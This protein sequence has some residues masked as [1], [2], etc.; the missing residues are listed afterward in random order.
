VPGSEEQPAPGLQEGSGGR[1]GMLLRALAAAPRDA[2][3]PQLLISQAVAATGSSGGVVGQTRGGDVV[4]LASHGYTTRQRSAC[5]PLR[6]GD[7]SLPLTYAATTGEPVW[8]ASQ[9]DTAARFPR[10]VELV[11]RDE[12]AYAA[13]PLRANGVSL[14]VLGISFAEQHDFTGADQDFLLALSD[15]C[16]IY[17]HQ[18][19][20]SAATGRAAASAAKLGHLVQTMSRAETADEVARL[21]AEEGS[22]AAGAEFANIAVLDP[23]AAPPTAHLYHAASLTEDVARRYAVIPVDASTPLGAVLQSGGEVWLPSLSDTATRYPALLRDTVA[24]GLSATASLALRGR[25]QQVIGA[26]G[27][28]WAQDQDFTSAQQEEVRVVARLAADALGRSQLL[29][30]ERAA[31][32]RTEGVQRAMTALVASASLAEV[33][34]AVFEHGLPPFGATAARLSLLSPRQP[35]Q[36]VT[37][38]AVGLPEAVLAS[39][40]ALPASVRSPEREVL[41]TSGT[42]YLPAPEDLAARFPTAHPVLVAAGHQAWAALPLHSGGR[43]L[44]VLTLAFPRRRPFDDGPGQL[45]LTALGSAIAD[46]LSRAIRHDSDHELVELVQGSLLAGSLPECPGVRLGARYMPAETQYGIGGDWYDA[47]PLPG[48]RILVVVGDVAGRGLTAAITMGQMRS[49][50]RALAPTHGPAALLEALDR[51]AGRTL[52]GSL[53]TAAAAIID[54]ADRTIRYCLAG[55]PPLLLRGPDGTVVTLA[56]ARRPLLG[57]DTGA[58][59]EQVI[60]FASGS[61]LVLFTDG[62]VER[63]GEIFDAGLSRLATALR[64]AAETDPASLCE[65]LVEQSLP[66][67]GRSD[68]TAILCA[69]LG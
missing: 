45:A 41:E 8:L 18:W 51:F 27:V 13:L 24:A 28:A 46:A 65:T 53:A 63:R 30:A 20:E 54:P 37:L 31:R 3:T 49:A 19:A 33:T 7:L 44:G 68:D 25:H 36:L 14:G 11:P 34:D 29:E 38:S 22:V 48:G 26:M 12:R 47:V 55:H 2:D 62:L 52:E 4:I 39:W 9:D 15:L 67:S 40:Q 16:A 57:L 10:I 35:D 23:D 56:A 58:R 64:S 1:L 43:R 66:P 69:F 42:V 21:L 32:Q 59:P 61:I 50:A 60:S 17:L 6:L 5:G